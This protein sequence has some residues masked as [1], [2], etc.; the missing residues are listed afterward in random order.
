M[1]PA[2]IAQ[3]N[4][5]F[6]TG[7]GVAQQATVAES[8]GNAAYAGQLYD[9]AAWWIGQSMMMAQQW[10]AFVPDG[11]HATLANV[12]ASAARAWLAMGQPMVAWQHLQQALMS[13]NQAIALNPQFAPYH[14]AAGT[15]LM[16]MGNVPEAQR[17]FSM[18]QLLQPGAPHLPAMMGMIQGL[19]PVPMQPSSAIPPPAFPGGAQPPQPTSGEGRDWVKTIGSAVNVLDS[20]FKTIGDFQDMAGKFG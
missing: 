9:Q 18:V 7:V 4:Q 5:P 19:R 16:A 17:A 14:A 11:V 13:L 12:H 3:L 15:V 20:I 1:N 2:I 10:G 6:L 8:Q